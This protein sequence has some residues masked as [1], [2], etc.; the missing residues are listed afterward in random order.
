[1]GTRETVTV[2]VKSCLVDTYKVVSAAISRNAFIG[3]F[4][5]LIP[6]KI[7]YIRVYG[8]VKERLL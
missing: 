8:E 2:Q 1:M 7:L 4:C 6:F 5:I 3:R